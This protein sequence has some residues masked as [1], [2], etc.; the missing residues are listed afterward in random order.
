MVRVQTWI[1]DALLVLYSFQTFWLDVCRQGNCRALVSE[2]PY[3]AFISKRVSLR[4][5]GEAAMQQSNGMQYCLSIINA[6]EPRTIR[7][8]IV[9][10]QTYHCR[11]HAVVGSQQ[12][13]PRIEMVLILSVQCIK[14]LYVLQGKWC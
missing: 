9:F 14:L 12:P 5:S 13:F 3:C 6:L 2:P 10:T 1:C 4:F 11:Q 8:Q 7:Y